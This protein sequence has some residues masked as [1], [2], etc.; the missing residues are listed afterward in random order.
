MFIGSFTARDVK[1]LFNFCVMLTAVAEQEAR[2]SAMLTERYQNA[3]PA[4]AADDGKFKRRRQDRNTQEKW[5]GLR[6]VT[7]GGVER[8]AKLLLDGADSARRTFAVPSPPPNSKTKRANL[9][10]SSLHLNGAA[11]SPTSRYP[12]LLASP[13]LSCLLGRARSLVPPYMCP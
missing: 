9:T 6:A 12:T 1:F 2:G 13:L 7:A 8:W 11:P 3:L 4:F 5:F 10:Q